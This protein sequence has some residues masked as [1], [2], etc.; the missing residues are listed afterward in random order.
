MALN[1]FQS[2]LNI[3]LCNQL[4]NGRFHYE[5]PEIRLLQWQKRFGKGKAVAKMFGD[6]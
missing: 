6:N 1:Y 3:V 5:N 4:I 2:K